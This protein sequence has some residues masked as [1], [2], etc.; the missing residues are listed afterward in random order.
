MRHSS[1]NRNSKEKNPSK[2]IGMMR[3]RILVSFSD[4]GVPHMAP[5]K[6]AGDSADALDRSLVVSGFEQWIVIVWSSVT[7]HSATREHPHD[8]RSTRALVAANM[9]AVNVRRYAAF[10]LK[11][12]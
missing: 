10:V 5:R 4:R 7:R 12:R 8:W 6:P 11:L 9:S 1:V 3:C 2:E